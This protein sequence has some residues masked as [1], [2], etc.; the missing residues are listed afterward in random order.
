MQ[1]ARGS[2]LM[3]FVNACR[4]TL[5]QVCGAE[6]ATVRED[7]TELGQS[8]P[9]QAPPEY[10]F[11][12]SPRPDDVNYDEALVKPFELPDPLRLSDGT[13]VDSATIWFERRRP[14]LLELFSA[15]IY[16]R[17]P[18]IGEVEVDLVSED[19]GACSGLGTRF[20]LDVRVRAPGAGSSEPAL[21]LHVL[22]WLPNRP[23]SKVPVFLGLN[24]FGNHTVHPDPSIRL[25]E[26]W[27]LNSAELG[28]SRY[29]ATEASRGLRARRWP[30]ELILA[31]GYGLGTLYAGDVD[32]DY[33]DGFQNGAHG[34]FSAGSANTR[35]PDAW[36]AIGAWAWGLSRGLDAIVRLDRVDAE[37]VGVIGHSRF[38]KAALWAAA[39]DQRFAWVVANNSG[40]GGAAVSRRRFG[41]LTRHLNARFPHWFAERFRAYDD[42]EDEL[43]VD[44]HELLA[45]IAP[46]PVYVA[47]A[48]E[49]L[50][51]DPDGQLLACVHA[52]PVYRMLGFEGL[53]GGTS[54]LP[55]NRRV[56][57]R[58]GYH[59]R[60]GGHDMITADWWHYLDF[61]DQHA[62]RR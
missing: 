57:D 40:R 56:G 62:V 51:G 58:I 39:Q 59:R 18:G 43:P 25:A 55:E 45:L 54:P 41:E 52:T 46:R 53:D 34:L 9:M 7:S 24:Y 4:A 38:G 33:H 44:Q 19:D 42:R 11:A 61:A 15:H 23:S 48:V 32:P 50:W 22:L 17:T 21:M 47:T 27:F 26:G 13:A 60:P 35:A 37:Q 6:T 20:E 14:E 30:I 49:D 3:G 28:I 29:S 1:S 31:R 5:F 10:P 2:G 8:W 36:G 16:G 12:V